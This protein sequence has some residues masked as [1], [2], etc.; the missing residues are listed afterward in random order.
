MNKC[1][2]ALGG[3]GC[4]LLKEYEVANSPETYKFIYM[5]SDLANNSNDNHRYILTT[6]RD[7][8]AIRIIGKDEIKA[9]I[10]NGE[11]PD[12]IDDFFLSEDFELIFVTTTFGGFGSAIV[13]ELSD[14]YGVKI[15]KYRLLNKVQ[16]DIKCKVIAFP[17]E[18]F[19]FIK[20][21]PNAVKTQF[22][23]NE[24][25]FINDFREKEARN[26]EWYL[27]KSNSMPC[28]QLYVPHMNETQDVH[29]C[30]D[31][32]D[33]EIEDI[34]IKNQFY[35]SAKRLRNNDVFISYSSTNQNIAD[36]LV[37]SAKKKGIGCWIA[38]KSI[39]AGSYAK[40]I[41]QGIR[42]AKVFVV[43][44]SSDST[45]SPHVK[46]ELNIATEH[47]KDGLVI[48]PFKIDNSQLDDECRYY[49]GRQEFYFADKPPLQEK[50]ND[51]VDS[52]KKVLGVM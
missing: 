15:K 45:T 9:L 36:M 7:G 2:I 12:F 14:Y 11:M 24:I 23:M 38:S 10:Y 34:D 20:N 39:D 40:Q 47:I 31:K 16:S 3:L 52:I 4:K 25:Q 28:V 51:F 46:N 44:V 13:S 41:V 6:Q 32:T 33:R 42:E 8:C 49:L 22:E 48:M 1:F 30:I 5:D 17:V 43:I 29:S 26:N 19:E 35:Y 37:E 21:F 18:D 27:R 50:I